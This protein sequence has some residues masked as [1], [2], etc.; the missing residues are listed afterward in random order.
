MRLLPLLALPFFLAACMSDWNKDYETMKRPEASSRPYDV[1][2]PQPNNP[3]LDP[4]RSVS[5]EDCTKPVEPRGN[6]RCR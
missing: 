5:D 3:D 4:K 1:A 6:L 2:V